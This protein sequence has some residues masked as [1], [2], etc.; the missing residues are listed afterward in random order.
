MKELDINDKHMYSC[1]AKSI[2]LDS[3]PKKRG[4]IRVDDYQQS[5]ALTS[6]GQNGSKGNYNTY[7]TYRY[8]YVHIHVHVVLFN[9]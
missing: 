1:I 9:Y 2:L 4:V 5:M 7:I 8:V 6:D 3:V